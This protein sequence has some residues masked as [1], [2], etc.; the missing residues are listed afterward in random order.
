MAL[1]T[2]FMCITTTITIG[3]SLPFIICPLIGYQFYKL[4]N[5]KLT[6]LL[7]KLPKLSSINNNDE[8]E[9][10]IIGKWYI[11]Y[12]YVLANQQG[13]PTKDLYILT[14]K[15]WFDTM[16]KEIDEQENTNNTN[17][18]TTVKINLWERDGNYFCLHYSKRDFDVS[19]SNP[20][21]QQ[22][23]VIDKIINFYETNLY[24]VVLLH[25]A[26][27]T[28]KSMIPLLLA[29]TLADKNKDIPKYKVSFCDTYNPTDPGD[30]FISLYNKI[31]PDKNSP[32]IV[33]LEEFDIIIHQVHYNKTDKHKYMPINILD[34]PSW[35]QFFDRFDRRY[36]PWVIL[37]LTSNVSPESINVLDPSYIRE[38]RVNQTFEI[39]KESK[40]ES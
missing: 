15:K 10:W 26:K 6:K 2:I 35:N 28:G 40:I 23:N 4:S 16:S 27:G 32:L 13:P 17:S 30:S 12:I 18:L 36:Y 25:G 39:I 24:S 37:I 11:G 22:S 14:S 5:Q 9:G 21:K 38:G 20:M 33:V 34:K 1:N 7:N 8:M 19:K 29:K 3:W 31:N